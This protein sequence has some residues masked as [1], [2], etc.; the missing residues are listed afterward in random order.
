MFSMTVISDARTH[1]AVE[2]RWRCAEAEC[3]ADATNVEMKS[4]GF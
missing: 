4:R 1:Q 2:A 3:K